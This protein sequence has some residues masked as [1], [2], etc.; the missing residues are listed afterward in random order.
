MST[1]ETKA[2]FPYLNKG[3][4][5]S[6][7]GIYHVAEI[8]ENR[9]QNPDGSYSVTLEVAAKCGELI[10]MRGQSTPLLPLWL[11]EDS[12]DATRCE[13]CIE[14]MQTEEEEQ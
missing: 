13:Q 8:K 9:K 5:K 10:R 1:L 7:R 2:Y 6:T 12:P 11:V 4:S 3:L 14:A